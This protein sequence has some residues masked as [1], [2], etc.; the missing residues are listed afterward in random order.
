MNRETRWPM[1]DAGT[2]E[3]RQCTTEDF[4]PYEC[5]GLGKCIHHDRR[6]TEMHDPATCALCD[7]KYDFGP[8]VQPTAEEVGKPQKETDSSDSQP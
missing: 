4:H 1:S 6:K 7:P 2:S 5:N 8:P 3:P